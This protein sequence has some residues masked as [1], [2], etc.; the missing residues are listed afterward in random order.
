MFGRTE[1]ILESTSAEVMSSCWKYHLDSENWWT[2]D[3]VSDAIADSAD[4]HSKSLVGKRVRRFSRNGSI[5][6][7]GGSGAEQM[8]EGAEVWKAHWDDYDE[9][10][11]DLQ[12]CEDGIAGYATWRSETT[13]QWMDS[14]RT[15]W[16]AEAMPG[17]SLRSA[18]A[19][20]AQIFAKHDT[21]LVRGHPQ[22]AIVIHLDQ[23]ASDGCMTLK[24][25]DGQVLTSVPCQFPGL[26]L[27]RKE[28]PE[29][30]AA[31][32]VKRERNSSP[33]SAKQKTAQSA[34][35]AAGASECV[36]TS[37]AVVSPTGAALPIAGNAEGRWAQ[38][39][40]GTQPFDFGERSRLSRTE[41]GYL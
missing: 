18:P 2:G 11:L 23:Q 30:V 24:F 38:L 9:E 6:G 20:C 4:A 40:T 35:A 37:L 15:Q 28:P 19:Q 33:K 8:C 7:W 17:S 1:L 26:R 14:R 34:K 41:P 16:D 25:E 22:T 13:R 10:D 12:M 31:S 27:L 39:L 3:P 36:R 21:V 29:P 5:V 32:A